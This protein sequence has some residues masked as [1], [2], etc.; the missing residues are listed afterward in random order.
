MYTSLLSVDFL[1][2]H[3]ELARVWQKMS[4]HVIENVVFAFETDIRFHYQA[5]TSSFEGIFAQIRTVMTISL[6]YRQSLTSSPSD[7]T[8]RVTINFL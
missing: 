4:R 6:A 8:Q 2:C 5:E 3:S 7:F 1:R